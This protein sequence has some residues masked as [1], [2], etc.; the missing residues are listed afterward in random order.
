[1]GTGVG[2][3]T[4]LIMSHYQRRNIPFVTGGIITESDLAHYNV[5]WREPL[6]VTFKDGTR[7]NSLPAPSSGPVLAF[8]LNILDG[9][10][11]NIY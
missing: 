11:F 4:A 3:A 6:Q 7:F 5:K 8:M 1:L 2:I 9:K 10:S